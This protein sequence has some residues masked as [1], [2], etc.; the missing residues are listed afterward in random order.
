MDIVSTATRSRMMAGIRSSNTN[1][2]LVVRKRLHAR[3]FRYKLGTKV[4]GHTPDIVLPKY[5]V[6]IFIHGCFWHR[7]QH[8]QYATTPKTNTKKWILKFDENKKRDSNIETI[9][10]ESGWRVAII[11][12]C[13]IKR[14]MQ[15]DWLFKWIIN[16]KTAYTS[17]PTV[18]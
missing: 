18:K 8:C 4:L 7:H 15:L 17:W 11:W 3:G 12:E 1:P 5:K 16:Q 14:N 6:V 2:E 13:W 10:I 9:L